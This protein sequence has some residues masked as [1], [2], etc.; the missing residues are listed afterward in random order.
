MIQNSIVP[1]VYSGTTTN[2]SSSKSISL[3]TLSTTARVSS[4]F[5]RNKPELNLHMYTFPVSPRSRSSRTCCNRSRIA[6]RV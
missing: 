1:R 2:I 5:T 3:A 4:Q 6:K